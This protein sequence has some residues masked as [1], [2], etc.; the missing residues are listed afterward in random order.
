MYP[1]FYYKLNHFSVFSLQINRGSGY[2]F[3]GNVTVEGCLSPSI[4]GQFCNQTIDNLSC[5]DQNSTQGITTSCRND[6]QRSCILQNESKLYS[7][8]LLGVSEEIIISATNVIYN[9]T[10]L[11][12][13]TINSSNI[14]LMCYARHGAMSSS[15]THDYSGNINNAPL[16]IQ[17]PKVGRWYIT[18]IPLNLSN[19]NVGSMNVCYSLEWKLLR[20]PI[21]KAGLNCT[22]ERYMLQVR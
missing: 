6:G 7:L 14:I 8:D 3:S 2:S 10:Q 18:V 15:F 17:S 4:S 19:E 11:S 16:I 9:Q 21:D 5:V 12:K 13:G 1:S 22:W 20:C